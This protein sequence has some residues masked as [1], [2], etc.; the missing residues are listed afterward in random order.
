VFRLLKPAKYF[1][2]PTVHPRKY[3]LRAIEVLGTTNGVDGLMSRTLLDP[4]HHGALH[5]AS[6]IVF[7]RC[8]ISPCAKKTLEKG[9]D[10]QVEGLLVRF[11]GQ[12]HVG[13]LLQAPLN[14]GRCV[15]GIRLDQNAFELQSSQQLF[16]GGGPFTGFTSV[17]GRLCQEC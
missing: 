12:E 15:Q 11:D 10:L 4:H 17:A 3:I 5:S 7:A 6:F 16:E 13:P 9:A 1:V 2:L 8:E 14:N